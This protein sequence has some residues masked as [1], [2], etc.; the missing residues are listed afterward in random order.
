MGMIDRVV[1]V[2]FAIVVGVLYLADSISGTA[3]LI[4]GLLAVI[5]LVTSIVAFCPLYVPLGISTLKKE[6]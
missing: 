1:R 2:I 3:A 4:L 6:K 5:M